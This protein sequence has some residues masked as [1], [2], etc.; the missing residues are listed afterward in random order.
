MERPILVIEDDPEVTALLREILDRNG[1]NVV[2][3][4]DGKEG[5]EVAQNTRPAAILCDVLL[6]VMTGFDAAKN[7]KENP[8]TGDIPVVL[9]TGHGYL[10]S[11]VAGASEWLLKPFTIRELTETISKV[12]RNVQ[13]QC[14][15]LP[16]AA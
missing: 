16:A 13:C 5:C 15:A 10:K 8:Q 11:P 6:P 2:V 14:G 1:F 7:L 12:V 4:H 9:M 3:A